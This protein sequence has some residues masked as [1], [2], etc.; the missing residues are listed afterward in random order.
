MSKSAE[1]LRPVRAAGF[2]ISTF[3]AQLVAKGAAGTRGQSIQFWCLVAE[4][5]SAHALADAQDAQQDQRI[6]TDAQRDAFNSRLQKPAQEMAL[7]E[8]GGGPK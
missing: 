3:R 7:T 5:L 4:T 2:L 8:R 6:E 1:R